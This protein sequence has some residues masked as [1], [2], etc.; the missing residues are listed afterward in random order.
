MH[1][2]KSGPLV[3]EITTAAVASESG[4]LWKAAPV[5]C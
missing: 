1:T 4:G 3:G 5:H 2:V